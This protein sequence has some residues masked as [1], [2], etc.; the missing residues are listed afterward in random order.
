MLQLFCVAI[1][2]YRPRITIPK[3][4]GSFVLPISAASY[5]IYL[6]HRIL[7][8]LFLPQPNAL[9]T[10]PLAAAG[11]VVSGVVTG[12]ILFALQKRLL[13]LLARSRASERGYG[14]EAM[15]RASS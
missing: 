2:L 5:H 10:P 9:V 1:L 7:P 11:A 6:F 15:H 8:D 4:A 14:Q 13:G 3:Q 12:L